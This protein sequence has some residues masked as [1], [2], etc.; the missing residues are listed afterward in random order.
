MV[1]TTSLGGQLFALVCTAR[2]TAVSAPRHTYRTLAAIATLA[3]GPSSALA[4]ARR[5]QPASVA[6]PKERPHLSMNGRL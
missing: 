5:A 2:L 4:F 6:P 3:T 1:G